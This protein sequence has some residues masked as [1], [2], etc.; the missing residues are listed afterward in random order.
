[1]SVQATCSVIRHRVKLEEHICLYSNV[2]RGDGG[3]T[4]FYHD[5]VETHNIRVYSGC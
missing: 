3:Y 1:M 2:E 4:H 5:A